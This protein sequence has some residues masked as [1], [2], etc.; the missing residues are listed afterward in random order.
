[1]R[2]VLSFIK[3]LKISRLFCQDQDQDFFFKTKIMTKTYFK[4]NTIFH[5]L[6][7]HREQDQGLDYIP[8]LWSN[9]FDHLLFI[10]AVI[11]CLSVSG[12][13]CDIERKIHL[14]IEK[15]YDL[16]SYLSICFI[17]VDSCV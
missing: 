17:A 1:M 14:K 6:E 5:V 12:Q 2:F 4:T 13:P 8:G 10:F 15:D 16:Y 11:D 9:Y 7:A 3:V